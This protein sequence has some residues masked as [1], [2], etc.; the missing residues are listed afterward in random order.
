LWL[1][2]VA[3]R[4]G[5]GGPISPLFLVAPMKVKDPVCGM[6]I[7]HS[8]AAAHGTYSGETVYFCSVG[9]QKKYDQSHPSRAA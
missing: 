4:R 9:C 2:A 3:D 1:V 5:P 8:T 7:E 6:V